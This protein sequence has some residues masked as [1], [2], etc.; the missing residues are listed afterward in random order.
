MH[1]SVRS[2]FE[3]FIETNT[4]VQ[5]DFDFNARCWNYDLFYFEI[6]CIHAFFFLFLPLKCMHTPLTG[7]AVPPVQLTAGTSY[8]Y[9]CT[10]GHI[11]TRHQVC[12]KSCNNVTNRLASTGL[13]S[14]RVI[15]CSDLR[16]LD[17]VYWPL[18]YKNGFR[19]EA[20]NLKNLRF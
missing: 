17:S 11:C 15:S 10:S 14:G 6:M 8:F 3:V 16:Q 5:S 9:W 13:I 2:C 7:A 4:P 19:S 12:P 18:G 1:S 20:F